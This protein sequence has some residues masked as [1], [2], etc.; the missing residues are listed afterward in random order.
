[1]AKDLINHTSLKKIINTLQIKND[2]YV[3]Y[4]PD[5]CVIDANYNFISHYG[6]NDIKQLNN[7]NSTEL[8]WG[9]KHNNHSRILQ[10]HYKTPQNIISI[11]NIRGNLYI[12]YKEQRDGLIFSYSA[13]NIPKQFQDSI[14]LNHSNDMR[15][16]HNIDI[17]TLYNNE[18]SNIFL[19]SSEQIIVFLLLSGYTQNDIAKF[20]KTSRSNIAKII[21]N[22]LCHKFKLHGYSANVL[23]DKLIHEGYHHFIPQDLIQQNN[24]I[25]KS[26]SGLNLSFLND[27]QQK[28]VNYLLINFNQDE[29]ARK[30]NYSRSMISKIILEQLC[31]IFKVN[32]SSTKAL[33]I[34]L[35]QIANIPNTL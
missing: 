34:K 17:I 13:K 27:V 21:G 22:N 24:Q 4:N 14:I 2:V 30:L 18:L 29:I 9:H 23:K 19:S 6:F 5:G 35:Q 1:M 25:I 31:P 10:L 16:R 28:I 33:L 8:N 3:V 12:D 32:H 20:L 11:M 7:I 26:N 15:K